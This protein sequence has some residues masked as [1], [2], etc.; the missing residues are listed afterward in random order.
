MKKNS[1]FIIAEAGVNH[2]GSL[3]LAKKLVRL[4]AKAGADA[5]KFQAFKAE[6]VVTNRGKMA[7]YQKKNIGKIESQKAMLAELEFKNTWYPIILKECQQCGIEFMST[8]HGGKESVRLLNRYVKRWK[9]GSGDLLNFILLN[10]IVKTKKPMILSSGMHDLKEVQQAIKYLLSKGYDRDSIS[11]LHCTTN[12]P[13]PPQQ[14]NLAA[15]VTMQKELGGITIGYSDHTQGSEVA[16]MAAALGMK[17]YECHFTLDKNLLGPD[18]KASA[19]PLELTERIKAIRNA[20]VIMGDKDKKPNAIELVG[21]KPQVTKSIVVT[22]DLKC[23]HI[24]TE[25][26]LG[27]KRPGDGVS[28]MFYEKFIGKS[29][30]RDVVT[31]QQLFFSD[32]ES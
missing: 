11:V 7:T 23:G 4:A 15:M 18:H 3:G 29:L 22:S 27:A 31:D 21:M 30:K 19:E 20:P 5:V 24:L 17:V 12:Y 26:D 16:I 1:C 10:E 25:K 13:C 6:Q 32:I 28:P 8:P 2:N 14:V 9:V